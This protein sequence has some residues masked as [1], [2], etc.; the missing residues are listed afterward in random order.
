M[1]TFADV[2]TQQITL[3][4]ETFLRVTLN[5]Q[6][7]DLPFKQI[8][9]RKVAFLDISGKFQLIEYCADCIV[10]KLIAQKAEF[11]TI[12]NPVSKSNA[13][14]HAVAVRW[15]KRVNPQLSHTIVARKSVGN[16]P[17]H[18]ATYR[19]VTTAADQ[20]LS[21]TADDAVFL[22]GKRILIM[23]DV[24][25]GG[26]TFKALQKLADSVNATITAKAV[27]AIE[28]GAQNTKD[29]VHLFELPTI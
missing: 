18:T 6:N 5:G 8:G 7:F 4:D 28:Q 13:L 22:K 11:D 16:D 19:S 2:K 9:E 1:D 24:Y 12:L 15:A 14:A 27:I 3:G 23:D 21:L 20:S 17:K 26:G 10:E 29:I 25:G